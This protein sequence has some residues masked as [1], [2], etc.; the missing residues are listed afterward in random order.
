MVARLD[1][2]HTLKA[3]GSDDVTVDML[4]CPVNPSDI[5]QIQGILSNILRIQ[6]PFSGSSLVPHIEQVALSPVDNMTLHNLFRRVSLPLTQG[7]N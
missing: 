5:N 7:K 2:E 6:F 1:E 4:L 3:M